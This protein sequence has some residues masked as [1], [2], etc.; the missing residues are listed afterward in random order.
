MMRVDINRRINGDGPNGVRIKA[1]DL[2]GVSGRNEYRE[3]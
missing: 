1:P 3:D 2:L